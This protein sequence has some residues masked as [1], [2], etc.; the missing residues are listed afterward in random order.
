[1]T[2]QVTLGPSLTVMVLIVALSF[3]WLRHGAPEQMAV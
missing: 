2:G 1:M 3:V